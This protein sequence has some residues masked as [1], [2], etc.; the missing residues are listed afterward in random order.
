MEI[1][2]ALYPKEV[3]TLLHQMAG[4]SQGDDSDVEIVGMKKGSTPGDVES[5][6]SHDDDVSLIPAPSGKASSVLPKVKPLLQG[7]SLSKNAFQEFTFLEK[8]E[9]QESSPAVPKKKKAENDGWLCPV[10]DEREAAQNR[11]QALASLKA[12]RAKKRKKVGRANVI[13]RKRRVDDDDEEEV[14]WSSSSSSE[15]DQPSRTNCS[16]RAA[17]LSALAARRRAEIGRPPARR[18]VAR[19][20]RTEIVESDDEEP[21]F[22]K[23]N[24]TTCAD[25]LA[26]I[27][28]AAQAKDA[29]ATEDEVKK[30]CCET[31]VLRPH[32]LVG[33]NW[34]LTLEAAGVCGILADEMG[35]GKTVQTIAY[36]A[37]ARCRRTAHSKPDLVVAP[38]STLDNWAAEVRKFAPTMRC[39]VYRGSA[40]ERAAFRG[41]FD[42]SQTDLVVTTYAYWERDN[43]GDDRRFFASTPLAHM[44]LDEGH[45]L[46]NP[47]ARRTKRLRELGARCELRSILSGTP[48]QNEPLELLSLLGFLM[49]DLELADDVTNEDVDALRRVLAPFVLRRVKRDVLASLPP[50]TEMVVS[51]ELDDK[52]RAVYDSVLARHQHEARSSD[53]SIFTEL[54]KAANHPLLLRRMYDSKALHR[55]LMAAAKQQRF[56]RSATVAQIRAELDT[57]CDLDLHE[58]CLDLEGCGDLALDQ[59]ALFASAKFRELSKLLPRLKLQGHRVLLFSQWTRILDLLGLLCEHLQLAACRLDGSTDV[60]SRHDLVDTF[61]KN[62]SHLDVF[63]LST[64]AGGLGVNLVGADVVVIFDSDWNPEIDRQAEDRAHRIGQTRPVTVYRLI[65]LC[66]VDED[67]N[68]VAAAK[69][70]RNDALMRDDQ[71]GDRSEDAGAHSAVALAVRK[72]LQQ[73]QEAHATDTPSSSAAT[74]STSP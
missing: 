55:L 61:N 18:R 14:S 64:R 60:A 53:E 45:S 35:L 47:Q 34:L 19:V 7:S 39:A 22:Q 5:S 57:Y 9:R 58:L 17:E 51:I 66:T 8:E 65:A 30:A 70:S 42:A 31:L 74:S 49:P 52:D 24:T 71:T 21:V 15:D 4:V 72:A 69:R 62:D 3:Q 38:A 63:L 25:C 32:Q 27:K 56:G 26:R 48:V 73:Y 67:I 12:E 10:R 29:V 33:V 59:D 2:L 68:R 37:I 46:K 36:L 6:G 44:V 1:G 50:K 43:C 41:S 13:Q 23:Q 54:R 20:E 11:K 40:A 28:A 16:Q